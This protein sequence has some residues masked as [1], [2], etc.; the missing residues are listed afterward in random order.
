VAELSC[1][2]GCSRELVLS[3]PPQQFLKPPWDARCGS[4]CSCGR[5]PAHLG[6]CSG[7]IHPNSQLDVCFKPN[8]V[9]V[10]CASSFVGVAQVVP[11]RFLCDVHN[12]KV[13][14]FVKMKPPAVACMELSWIHVMHE[15]LWWDAL[16]A[17]KRLRG[18]TFP[19]FKPCRSS[20]KPKWCLP[21]LLH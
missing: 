16:L 18:A 19:N 8:G 21:Q 10:G 5:P 14:K 1:F 11:R 9:V 13:I 15:S 2:L 12:M 17:A 7:G 4:P 6:R 3:P 20:R